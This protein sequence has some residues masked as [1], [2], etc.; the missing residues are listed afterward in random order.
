MNAFLDICLGKG[1]NVESLGE[2][3]AAGLCN[4]I[5]RDEKGD[6]E[7]QSNS[8]GRIVCLWFEPSGHVP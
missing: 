3:I 6:V 4:N 5:Y 2:E 1:T 7:A 8:H